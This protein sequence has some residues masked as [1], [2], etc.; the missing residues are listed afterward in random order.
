[1]SK[2]FKRW[3]KLADLPKK[4]KKQQLDE[5]IGG[6][7]G[8]PAISQ[9]THTPTIYETAFDHFLSE[10]YEKM[11]EDSG[12]HTDLGFDPEQTDPAE[13]IRVLAKELRTAIETENWSDVSRVL[14]DLE[15]LTHPDKFPST[16]I[17]EEQDYGV[18]P[19]DYERKIVHKV[20][21]GVANDF[22]GE[23]MMTREYINGIIAALEELKIND[24]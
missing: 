8:I 4:P 15:T 17:K 16:W 22:S 11:E 24:F 23:D 7:V 20:I 14:D 6:I 9:I 12:P 19:Y 10:K 3:A 13:H 18:G 1:M 21:D 5:N 2:E